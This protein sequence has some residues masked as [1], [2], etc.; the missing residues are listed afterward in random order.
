MAK[1]ITN[2]EFL[3]IVNNKF[4]FFYTYSEEYQGSSKYIKIICPDHG[5]F[6]CN[7]GHH[8]AGHG[9]QVC[10]GKFS[11]TLS[12]NGLSRLTKSSLTVYIKDVT[13]SL[14]ETG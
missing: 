1:K 6:L 12:E 10:G 8:L 3:E 13:I 7:A 9:C 4:N 2:I 11:K 5:E 14:E